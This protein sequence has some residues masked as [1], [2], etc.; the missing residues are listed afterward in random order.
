[1]H[2]P[3]R[4]HEPLNDSPEPAPTRPFGR[5]LK[6]LFLGDEPRGLLL[7]VVPTAVAFVLDLV[8]RAPLM[9]GWAL[10][11]KAIYVSS[12]AVSAATW[13]LPLWCGAWLWKTKRRTAVVAF[14]ALY[15]FPLAT[16]A[17][18]GQIIYHRVVHGYVGR[19]TVRLGFAAR[20]T[21][22]DWFIGWGS[23]TAALGMVLGGLAMT[24]LL[25]Y[26]VRRAA[27]RIGRRPPLLLVLTFPVALFVYW[28]DMVDSRFLQAATPD[29]CMVHGLVHA[30]RVGITR[31]GLVGRGITLR[32]P[33]ALPP[34][35]PAAHRPNVVLVILE[36]VRADVLCSEPPPTCKARFFDEVAGDRIPLGRLTTPT[37]GT[38]GSCMILW[39]GQP[40]TATL[41][42]AHTAPVLW[43]VARA[44]G[45]RTAY[46]T[47]QNLQFENFGAF[48]ENA[49]IDVM[50]S[51][52]ELGDIRQE[53]LGAPDERAIAEMLAYIQGVPAGAPYFG[54]LHLSNTHAPYRTDPALLPF[55]PESTNPIGDPYP[56]SNH[57]RN[58]VLLEERQVS[59]FLRTL[60][61]LPSWDDTVVV[62][63]SDHGE[64]FRERGGL[65][66]LHSLFEEE[67]RIPGFVLTGPR[68]LD[69]AQKKA[70][71][72][73][74]DRR[75]F[76]ADVNAT[77]VDLLGAGD[78]R[79]SFPLANPLARSLLRPYAPTEE[80][81]TLM[82]TTTAVWDAETVRYGG[83]W[84]ESLLSGG[85]G[86]P[87]QC[88]KVRGDPNERTPLGRETCPPRLQA[89]TAVFEGRY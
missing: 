6:E 30:A 26:L 73:Y 22:R 28:I 64:Q 66:H 47:S 40:V 58:S 74:H 41:K 11:G 53:Q 7:F 69:E 81:L 10:Q 62:L 18:A 52:A 68:G 46:I 21:V 27:P 57:Y 79:A 50:K 8:I 75:T 49:G 29:V 60:R 82:S 89:A 67:V 19:D 17:Y 37:S 31:K 71:A 51:A 24:A 32:T 38:F 80:P 63:V 33:A 45:Y 43:E 1:M 85:P 86:L 23:L 65:Y 20:G 25:A 87:W 55:Q 42:E 4:A 35:A 34:L 83:I 48:V 61:T 12:L 72:T 54:V 5:R 44:E 14:F 3:G 39:T 59:D 56:L 77:I 2:D 88:F 70:L 15:V 84:S 16:C 78:V 76:T 13:A 9:A 36:S